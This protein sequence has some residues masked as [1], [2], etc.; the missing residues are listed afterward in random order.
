MDVPLQLFSVIEIREPMPSRRRILATVGTVASLSTAGCS[1][2][3]PSDGSEDAAEPIEV[4]VSNAASDVVEIAVRVL[5]REGMGLFSRVFSLE[6]GHFVSRGAIETTPAEVSAFT[7]DGVSHT[8]EYDPD[9]PGDFDCDRADI[10]LTVQQD[11]SI[12]EWYKC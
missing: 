11:N 7:P 3:I 4:A 5:D 12:R 1:G 8:W 6:P 10:G 2:I 9:L